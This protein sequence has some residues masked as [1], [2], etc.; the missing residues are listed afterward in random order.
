MATITFRM[1]DDEK[2]DY[3]RSAKLVGLSISEWIR[4]ACNGTSAPFMKQYEDFR[5]TEA[6]ATQPGNGSENGNGKDQDLLR[7]PAVRMAG[8]RSSVSR[9]L[10]RRTAR[11]NGGTVGA[12]ED[13]THSVSRGQRSDGDAA[14]SDSVQVDVPA[15]P[16]PVP[17]ERA[18]P[19]KPKASNSIAA[20]VASRTGHAVG[21]QCFDCVQV[22]RF[23]GQQ[24]KAS[25]PKP[26]K[27]G[28]R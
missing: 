19:V 26:A 4:K 14:R 2:A 15:Q 11:R 24:R 23:I 21:C 5:G 28:R 27:K 9:G 10:G 3:L 17:L 22:E 7:A 20:M 25:E 12:I 1:S 6:L 18:E 13:L 8:R 16:E